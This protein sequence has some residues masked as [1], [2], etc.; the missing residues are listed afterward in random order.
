MKVLQ[1]NDASSGTLAMQDLHTAGA[2]SI[3]EVDVSGLD[4]FQLLSV[5]P[6]QFPH[7]FHSGTA[8]L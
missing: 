4:W 7:M 2:S 5:P 1:L 8:S 6:M 3:H